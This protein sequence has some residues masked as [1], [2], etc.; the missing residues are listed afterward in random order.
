[1]K[2]VPLFALLFVFGCGD[3]EEYDYE[4]DEAAEASPVDADIESKQIEVERINGRLAG[5]QEE[6]ADLDGYDESDHKTT[7]MAELSVLETTNVGRKQALED[8]IAQL[9]QQKQALLSA[10]VTQARAAADRAAADA[11]P[12]TSALTDADAA[13]D[14]AIAGV[15]DAPPPPPEV[16]EVDAALSAASAKKSEGTAIF[17]VVHKAAR[18]LPDDPGQLEALLQ[19]NQDASMLFTEAK[20]LYAS[21]RDEA[22]NPASIDKTTKTLE[23]VLRL[24]S[25]YGKLIEAKLGQ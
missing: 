20:D 21:V 1:M 17:K 3:F 5:L 7:L 10:R 18:N 11:A 6:R 25:K 15:G 12:K 22:P 24:L 13:L 16:N 4:G 2:Y 8:E 23:N 14:A 19:K 9:M